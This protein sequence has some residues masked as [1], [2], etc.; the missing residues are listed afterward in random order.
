MIEDGYIETEVMEGRS[1]V[2]GVNWMGRRA[3]GP[4][5]EDGKLFSF[6][7]ESSGSA[8]SRIENIVFQ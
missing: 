6:S 8:E 2:I 3:G 1:N 5:G 7:S 4:G